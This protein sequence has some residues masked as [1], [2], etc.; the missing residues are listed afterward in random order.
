MR[1]DLGA[2]IFEQAAYASKSFLHTERICLSYCPGRSRQ[3]LTG[4][5]AILVQHEH[6][7]NIAEEHASRDESNTAKNKDPGC[8]HGCE[9]GGDE[10][11]RG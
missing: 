5:S 6:G 2:T 9:P 8:T 4:L 11:R 3:S 10:V 7:K 1:I